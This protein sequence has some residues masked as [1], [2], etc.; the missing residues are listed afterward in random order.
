VR[1]TS[2]KSELARAIGYTLSGWEVLTRYGHDGRIEIDNNAAERAA[3]FYSLIGSA[4]LNGLDPEAYLREVLRRI[5]DHRINRIDHVPG[6]QHTAVTSDHHNMPVAPVRNPGETLY[7]L[8]DRLEAA[9]GPRQ[10]QD[11]A[12][13][14]LTPKLHWPSVKIA[15]LEGRYIPRSVRRVDIP[16]RAGGVF[17]AA[18]CGKQPPNPSGLGGRLHD[19]A[20]RCGY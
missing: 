10:T 12:K 9:L 19:C 8:L 5:A 1:E 16:K 18:F 3:A 11:G 4:M 15:L 7:Q 20:K 14:M 2:K 13:L 17:N 6:L